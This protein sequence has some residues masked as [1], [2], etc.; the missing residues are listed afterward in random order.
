MPAPTADALMRAALG[1]LRSG[2]FNDAVTRYDQVIAQQPDLVEAYFFRG[3][4]LL[5]LGRS[6][7]AVASYDRAI[8]LKPDL[9]E[10]YCNRGEALRSLNRLDQALAS[11]EHAI[12]LKP[13]YADAHNN[14]GNAL[15]NL[16][17]FAEA[18]A[19]YDR[20][21]ASQPDHSRAYCNRGIALVHLLRPEEAIRSFE[22]AIALQPDY[23]AAWLD[24]A[25]ALRHLGRW[26]EALAAFTGYLELK[27]AKN[28]ERRV[29]LI[30]LGRRLFALDFVPAIYETEAQIELERERLLARLEEAVAVDSADDI[31]PVIETLFRLTGFS[32]ALQQ[33]NDIAVMVSYSALLQ[34][35][36]KPEPLSR[37]AVV[38][39]RGPIRVG[40]ASALLRNHNGT[41]WAYEW[42]NQLPRQDYE[43]FSYSL[44]TEH[45]DVTA[46][47]AGL[48]HFA[49]LPFVSDTYREA[50]EEMRRDMLDFLMLPDIGMTPE[51][52]VLSQ[53]RIAPVQFAAWGYPTTSGSPNIDFFLSSDLMEPENAQDHYSET[54]IRLPN[55]GL[56][57]LPGAAG[58]ADGAGFDLP[59]DRV[60]Y[61]SIQNLFKYLPQYDRVWPCIARRLPQAFF[62]FIEGNPGHM[63]AGFRARLTR[64]FACEGLDAAD[65]VRVLPQMSAARFAGLLHSIHINIDSI[66]W[67]GGNTTL[68]SLEANCPLVTLPTALMRGRHSYAMLRMIGLDELIAT[69]F[70]DFIDRLVRLGKDVEFRLQMVDKLAANRPRM[71][72]DYEFIAGLDKFLKDTF[73]EVTN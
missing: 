20:A 10:A 32:I 27:V 25:E 49:H 51:S 23:A 3:N 53:F 1:R 68:H 65:Y 22:R 72:R 30:E 44:G 70:D 64:A 21:I 13:D 33:K 66:G 2:D 31:E 37:P 67:S 18:V 6:S 69:S 15:W 35:L 63:T 28:H 47:F 7:E 62:I 54:L 19:S 48:G 46:K 38:A 4:A 40:I 42:F 5:A 61:G 26:R 73:S 29:G 17:R 45:D 12:T 8:F 60:L 59:Q 11:L 43:F 55:L 24:H 56:F 36:L 52:R 14:R 58:A 9:A 57:L 41:R 71:Y 39:H 16:G 50:I 34:K